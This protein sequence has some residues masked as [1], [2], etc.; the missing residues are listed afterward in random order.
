MEGKDRK[1]EWIKVILNEFSNS[2][3][4]KHIEIL[5]N[6]GADCASSSTLIEGAVKV[7]NEFVKSKTLD[8][9]FDL[10]KTNYYNSP[11]LTKTG[12]EITLIFEKCTCPIVKEGVDN[13]ILCHCTVGHT[14]KI[15]QT[16][17]NRNV[18]VE[19]E[20][21]ILAGDKICKQIIAIEE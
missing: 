12:N 20:E 18:E 16:L 4:Y 3:D 2:E 13:P 6:C 1:T 21:S 5:E 10:F 19:L 8:E 17:F 14:K 11:N 15:F 7:S 9:I